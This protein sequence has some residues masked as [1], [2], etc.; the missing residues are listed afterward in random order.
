MHY[1]ISSREVYNLCNGKEE[2][3]PKDILNTNNGMDNYK[4]RH[5]INFAL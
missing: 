3:S 5:E 2:K 4:K 1:K